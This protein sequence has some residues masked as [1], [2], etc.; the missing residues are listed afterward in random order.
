MRCMFC[1]AETFKI[2]NLEVCSSCGKVYEPTY[3]IDH[4][5]EDKDN[6]GQEE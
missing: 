5:E 6:Y 3:I 4:P 1:T 2:D